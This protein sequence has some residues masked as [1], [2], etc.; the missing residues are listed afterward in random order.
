[1]GKNDKKEA[2]FASKKISELQ[3]TIFDQEKAI[4]SLTEENRVLKQ[5]NKDLKAEVYRFGMLS[6]VLAAIVIALILVLI[7]K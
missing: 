5:E 4:F 2:E 1:M 3:N 7:V 6:V